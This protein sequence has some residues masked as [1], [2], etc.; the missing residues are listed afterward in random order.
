MA[1]VAII[2]FVVDH[3][4]IWAVILWWAYVES[5]NVCGTLIRLVVA[6]WGGSWCYGCLS[7]I[8]AGRTDYA[9]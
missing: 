2:S 4:R 3:S 1:F 9:L 5:L 7:T 6:S 8:E